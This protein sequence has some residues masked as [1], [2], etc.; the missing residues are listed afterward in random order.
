MN[1]KT[2]TLFAVGTVSSISRETVRC[3]VA[4]DTST[5]GV[6]PVTVMVSSSWLTFSSA[7]MVAVKLVRSSRP[8]FLTVANPAS[9]KVTV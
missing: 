6:A 1:R 7:S 2:S 5:S 3:C 9:E 4:L 8:S